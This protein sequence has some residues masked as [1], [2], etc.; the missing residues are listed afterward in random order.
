[1]KNNVLVCRNHTLKYMGLTGHHGS[2]VITKAQG[3]NF[4]YTVLTTFSKFEVVFKN[5]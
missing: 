3:E 5:V 1:M 2:N 4:C